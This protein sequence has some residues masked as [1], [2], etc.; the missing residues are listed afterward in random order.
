[1]S[2]PT[3]F[4]LPIK[5][6]WLLGVGIALVVSGTLGIALAFY[7][8]LAS[9]IFFG[10]LALV[11]GGFQLWHGLTTQESSWSG[12]AVHLL[13]ALAYLVLGGLLLWDPLGGSISLTLVLTVFLF[14]LGMFRLTYAWRCWH[15]GWRWGLMLLGA[16]T[17]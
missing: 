7:L 17:W 11:T 14:A 5:W 2:G 8:T 12:R 4:E 3:K 13:V 15:R 1:M 6:G 10:A 16:V 9:V